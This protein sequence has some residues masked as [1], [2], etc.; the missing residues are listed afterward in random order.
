LG[1]EQTAGV[2]TEVTQSLVWRREKSKM[3]SIP[4]EKNEK[5]DRDRP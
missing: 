4:R 1:E 2:Q 3:V 5:G